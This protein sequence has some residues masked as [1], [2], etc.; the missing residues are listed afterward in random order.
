VIDFGAPRQRFGF[1]EINGG[2]APAIRFWVEF[3]FF[4]AD[5]GGGASDFAAVAVH[6]RIAAGLHLFRSEN[7][8]VKNIF[9]II[10]IKDGR[11]AAQFDVAVAVREANQTVV[12]EAAGGSAFDGSAALERFRNM[13]LEVFL[14]DEGILPDITATWRCQLPGFGTSG[15]GQGYSQATGHDKKTKSGF[16][17]QTTQIFQNKPLQLMISR[18]L[19]YFTCSANIH[20]KKLAIQ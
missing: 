14:S 5:Y 3:F 7:L 4:N 11:T 15:A 16:P 9:F 10:E 19:T 20:D 6:A 2:E 12:F 8:H 1:V 17:D 13:Q 18:I